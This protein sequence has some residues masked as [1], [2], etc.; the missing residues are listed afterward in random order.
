MSGLLDLLNDVSPHW[1]AL[2][3]AI[4]WQ[5]SLLVLLVAVVAKLLRRASPVVRYWLWQLVAIKLLLMPL[6]TQMV[7]VP[8]PAVATLNTVPSSSDVAVPPA[9][10][11][12]AA[13]P[14]QQTAVVQPS[15]AS[16]LLAVAPTRPKL[17]WPSALGG[18]GSRPRRTSCTPGLAALATIETIA[19]D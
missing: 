4:T 11:G 2:M 6:W 13:P 1:I 18:L 8:W 19:T 10:A 9:T 7:P 16:P 17:T 5:S 3:I 14:A 15:P 12:N